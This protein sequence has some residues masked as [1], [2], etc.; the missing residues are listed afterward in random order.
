MIPF[1]SWKQMKNLL[2]F[3]YEYPF[4]ISYI[5]WPPC[6]TF[7]LGDRRSALQRMMT[8]IQH[9]RLISAVKNFDDWWPPLSIFKLVPL[10]FFWI[11]STIYLFGFPTTGDCRTSLWR[12]PSAVKN[13]D[14]WWQPFNTSTLGHRRFVLWRLIITVRNFDA[15]CPPF[16]TLKLDNHR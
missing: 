4:W 15:W 2:T 3:P 13:S 12:L 9:W 14:A 8:T 11:F 10:R 5:S 7:T 16:S 1:K 6:I